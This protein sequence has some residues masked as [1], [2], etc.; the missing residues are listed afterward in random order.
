MAKLPT[1][2]VL[3]AAAIVTATAS[4]DD[5]ATPPPKETDI[6]SLVKPEKVGDHTFRIGEVTLDSSTRVI[7]FPAEVN[8]TEGMIEFPVSHVNGRIHEAIFVTNI[9]PI[10]LQTAMLLN[11]YQTSKETFALPL[12]EPV[13]PGVKMPP[14][15]FPPANPKSHVK[16]SVSWTKSGKLQTVPLEKM[17][18]R[19]SETPGEWVSYAEASNYWVFTGS[20]EEM[21]ATVI[22]MGGAMVG[23]R[24]AYD[25]IMNPLPDDNVALMTWS[26]NPD[27]IP[28]E[29][30]KVTIHLAPVAST[31]PTE[32]SET[33]N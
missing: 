16:I 14:P 18:M 28:E 1:S 31:K 3:V 15:E 11:H 5:A 20:T 4:E 22:D 17:L 12:K 7:S 29:G 23:S 9:L 25:C 27:T 33:K 10:Q 19:E 30:M 13:R 21:G 2:A 32:S 8:M 6:Q 24:L 26:A